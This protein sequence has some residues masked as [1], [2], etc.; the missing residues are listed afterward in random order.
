M[1]SSIKI[2]DQSTTEPD[3]IGEAERPASGTELSQ[4]SDLGAEG[5]GVCDVNGYCA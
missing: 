5:F 3:T 1:T 4:V 2:K